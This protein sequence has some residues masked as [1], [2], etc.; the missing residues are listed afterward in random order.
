[1]RKK[2][3]NEKCSFC[4]LVIAK[5]AFIVARTPNIIRVLPVLQQ[6][7]TGKANSNRAGFI[8]KKKP[9]YPSF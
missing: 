7:P 6:G 4:F 5:S 3:P 9:I 1:M 2:K 8:C